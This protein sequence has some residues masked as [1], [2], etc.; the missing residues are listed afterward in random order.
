MLRSG[1]DEPSSGFEIM[2]V[3]EIENTLD[4]GAYTCKEG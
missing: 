1:A 2:L 4:N 3:G